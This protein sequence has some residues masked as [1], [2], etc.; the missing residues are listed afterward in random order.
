ALSAAVN[1]PTYFPRGL[2]NWAHRFQRGATFNLVS[3]VG[4]DVPF[5]LGI[6]F[7]TV[8]SA[9]DQH[10]FGWATRAVARIPVGDL[11]RIDSGVD[12]EG[13]RFIMDRVGASSLTTDPSM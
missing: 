4:Y 12:Y 2:V 9:L 6:Q 10:S 5:G 7:G 8:P 1:S 11:Y 3:S 13:Q